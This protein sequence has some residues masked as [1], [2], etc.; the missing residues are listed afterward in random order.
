MQAATVRRALGRKVTMDS[1]AG[2]RA[3][4]HAMTASITRAERCSGEL[5]AWGSALRDSAG[6]IVAVTDRLSSAGDPE[7]A[8]A[9]STAYLESV[10]HVVL[11]WIWLERALA[12]EGKTGDFCDGKRAAA[13]YFFSYELP[14][15]AVQFDLL[16]SLD[17][18]MLELSESWF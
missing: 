14:K 11:A 2:L 6:Q 7:T 8:L 15:A 3:L 4:L 9:D 16:A 18:S 17:S 10:G 12:A 1:G 5:R 13:R